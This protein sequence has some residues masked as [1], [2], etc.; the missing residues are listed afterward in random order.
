MSKIEFGTK[1]DFNNVLI[2]PKRSI[3]KSRSQVSLE[4]KFKF[5][6]SSSVWNGVP[7]ISANM[8]TTGTFEVY[9]VLSSYN[10]LTMLHKFYTVGDYID[11]K[12][13]LNPDLF[14]VSTG[15]SDDDYNKLVSIM[16]VVDCNWI[17][18]DIAN[19]YL[20]GMVE[21]CLLM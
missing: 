5:R 3:I 9:E 7:I 18:I 19:G 15:I 1:L 17:C 6:N 11:N 4:R 2:R 10:M 8:D 21:Y 16:D 13:K 12:D 20:D 14:G